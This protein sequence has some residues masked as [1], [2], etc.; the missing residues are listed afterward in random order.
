MTGKIN[1]VSLTAR[2]IPSLKKALETESRDHGQTTSNYVESILLSRGQVVSEGDATSLDFQQQLEELRTQNEALQEKMK[3]QIPA[4]DLL[5]EQ[6]NSVYREQ[7]YQARIEALTEHIERLS[8]NQENTVSNEAYD[9]LALAKT[10]LESDNQVLQAQ[11]DGLMEE[12][13]STKRYSQEKDDLRIKFLQL[14]ET[15]KFLRMNNTDLKEQVQ[16][17]TEEVEVTEG[18]LDE[19]A[20][21]NQDLT[22]AYEAKVDKLQQELGELLDIACDAE[23]L[24]ITKEENN[25]LYDR[26][27][28]LE[29]QLIEQQQA[30]EIAIQ[31]LD[32]HLTDEEIIHPEYVEELQST[33]AIYK[34]RITQLETDLTMSEDEIYLD[35]TP[36]QA[37]EIKGYFEKLRTIYDDRSNEELILGALYC[38][39]ENERAFFRVLVGDYFNQK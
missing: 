14:Q 20:K 23:D 32:N 17:L 4:D 7:K 11:I 26:I 19:L 27:D 6:E 33:I 16:K 15:E 9:I 38:G 10:S 22:D 5:R 36:E 13:Q 30:H 35:L 2:V 12:L 29:M 28:Q 39:V 37:I 21:T 24:E 8:V 1:R 34:K 18:A 25:T 31:E 3:T